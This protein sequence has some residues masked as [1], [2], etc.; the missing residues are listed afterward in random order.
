MFRRELAENA[1]SSLR[2]IDLNPE[3]HHR[4]ERDTNFPGR[5]VLA[6]FVALERMASGFGAKTSYNLAGT[7]WNFAPRTVRRWIDEFETSDHV[8]YSSLAET[9][10]SA[11]G[12]G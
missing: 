8:F 9:C 4:C 11:V 7:I 3:Q 12:S 10:E 6:M 5:K 2:N 1:L